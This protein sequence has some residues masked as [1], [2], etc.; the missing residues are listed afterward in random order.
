MNLL[1]RLLASKSLLSFLTEMT[2]IVDFFT[3]PPLYLSVW[4]GRTWIG[5][6]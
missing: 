1:L 3:L 6:R 2:T 5:L 4:L